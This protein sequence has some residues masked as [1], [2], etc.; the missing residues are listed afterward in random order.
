MG[1]SRQQLCV[2]LGLGGEAGLEINVV[3]VSLLV[4]TRAGAVMKSS[5]VEIPRGRSSGSVGLSA[6]ETEVDL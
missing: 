6:K 5:W 2:H 3:H 1:T 4:V